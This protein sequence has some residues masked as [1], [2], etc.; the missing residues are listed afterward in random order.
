[1][2]HSSASD[3]PG[4]G[5]CDQAGH[6]WAVGSLSILTSSRCSLSP[7]SKGLP[8]AGCTFGMHGDHMD[9]STPSSS[10]LAVHILLAASA[11]AGPALSPFHPLSLA[12]HG[13]EHKGKALQNAPAK[14]PHTPGRLQLSQA[15]LMHAA[16]QH[17][18]CRQSLL[19]QWQPGWQKP[20][21]DTDQPRERWEIGRV[22][23]HQP[24]MLQ[25]AWMVGRQHTTWPGCPLHP[26]ST[27]N[28]HR[29]G[30]TP[31]QHVG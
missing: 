4:S 29:S 16:V 12:L 10:G 20:E 7:E 11:A 24:Q 9:A 1:M 14:C 2:M 8:L 30:H 23:L 6:C 3:R 15:N 13:V 5:C 26:H 25:P 17:A 19:D 21:P 18:C 28:P 22:H 27:L 31:A